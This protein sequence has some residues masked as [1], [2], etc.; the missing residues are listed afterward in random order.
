MWMQLVV[1]FK[2]FASLFSCQ[3]IFEIVINLTLFVTL[4]I[5][6]TFLAIF[7][8]QPFIMLIKNAYLNFLNIHVYTCLVNGLFL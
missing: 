3:I 1:Q 8:F 7:L 2:N 6:V 4:C 5:G